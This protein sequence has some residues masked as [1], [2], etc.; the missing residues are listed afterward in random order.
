MKASVAKEEGRETEQSFKTKLMA[1]LK[2]HEI[3]F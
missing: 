3:D 1:F 2:K